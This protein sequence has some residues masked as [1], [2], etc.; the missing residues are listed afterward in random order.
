MGFNQD[1]IDEILKRYTGESSTA[2]SVPSSKK[3]DK[4]KTKEQIEVDIPKTKPEPRDEEK[5]KLEDIQ[6]IS[7]KSSENKPG[8]SNKTQPRFEDTKKSDDSRYLTRSEIIKQQSK[9]DV[10]RKAEEKQRMRKRKTT[11]LNCLLVFFILVFLGSGGYLGYYFYNIKKSQDSFDDLKALITD[12]GN[13][14]GSGTG[15]GTAGDAESGGLEYEV[16]NG[17]KVQ[18]KFAGVYAKN[19]DFIGWLK[20]DG[21]NVD[22]PVMYTPTD[23]QKYLHLDFYQEYSSS[24]TLFLSKNSDPFQPSDNILIYGHNMKAGTMFHTLLQYESQEF[25]KEHKTFTFDTINENGTYEVIAAF[26][27]EIDES[28]DK[29]FKYYEFNNAADQAEFDEYVSKVKKM[30]PYSID[31]T[32]EF[33]DKLVTLS[34]CAYHASEGRYVVVAKK[35]K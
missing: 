13:S 22:Y 19:N 7:L 11:I 2:N 28:N 18:T 14:G 24:G 17:V 21:T 5:F 15:T 35:I 4:T 10:V 9:N 1:E 31:T 25:Y 3:V 27:T 6:R 26:R 34:T 32:A 8:V 30:T 33:G 12:D 16:I 23:E 29:L 20:I